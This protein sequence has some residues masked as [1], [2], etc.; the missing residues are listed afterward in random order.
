ML[1][2]GHPGVAYEQG[3]RY[4]E[5]LDGRSDQAR[6]LP[7]HPGMDVELHRERRGG[8]GWVN[9]FSKVILDLKLGLSQWRRGEKANDKF[10]C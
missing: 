7:L 3:E 5:E 1:V 6:P 8:G 2:V 9:A 10:Q 4:Q